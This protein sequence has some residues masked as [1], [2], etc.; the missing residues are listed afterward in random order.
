MSVRV[1]R[2]D[3]DSMPQSARDAIYRNNHSV[4]DILNG[5]AGNQA[6]DELTGWMNNP[7]VRHR[8]IL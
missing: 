6:R 2:W 1:D 3:V 5:R 8:R 7:A 4:Q